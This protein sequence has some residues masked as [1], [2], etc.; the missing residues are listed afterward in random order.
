MNCRFINIYLETMGGTPVFMGTQP[1]I[2]ILF[3]Y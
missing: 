3:E 2:K 1:P